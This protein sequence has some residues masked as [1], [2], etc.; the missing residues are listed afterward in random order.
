MPSYELLNDTSS[1]GGNH[2]LAFL[3]GLGSQ[4]GAPE[5][6]SVAVVIAIEVQDRLVAAD[7]DEERARGTPRARTKGAFGG[8][9][10]GIVATDAVKG[11]SFGAGVL[12][13][14][15]LRMGG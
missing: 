12:S 8:P 11:A 15:A 6:E 9:N 2:P 4:V 1:R 7:A 5:P 13:G 10:E 3:S 14:R